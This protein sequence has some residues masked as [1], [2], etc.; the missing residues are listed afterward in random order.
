MSGKKQKGKHINAE[1]KARH[2]FPSKMTKGLAQDDYGV[3]TIFL[4]R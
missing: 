3:K 4:D 2:A 1:W